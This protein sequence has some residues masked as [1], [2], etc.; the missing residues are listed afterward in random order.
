VAAALVA[1]EARLND[2]KLALLELER[3]LSTAQGGLRDRE[4]A[5]TLAEHQVVL[6]RE[7]AAGLTRRAEEAGAES[8]RMRERLEEVCTR[9]GE[10]A[11]KRAALATEREKAQ[12]AAEA[13]ELD[14]TAVEAELRRRR[15]VASERKQ[16]SLDLF[17]TEAEKRSACE[18]IRERQSSLA[19]RRDAA[20]ARRAEL[21]ARLGELERKLAL[22]VEE[23]GALDAG[24]DQAERELAEVGGRIESLDA[25]DREGA[26]ALSRLREEAAAAESRLN[27]LL[28][29]KR[30]FDG[31]SEGVKALLSA[32]ER[33]AGVVGVVADVLEVPA[34]YLD[35]LEAS[36]GEASAF[37]L[38]ED[39]AARARALERLRALES[40]RATLV[41]LESLSPGALPAVPE[42]R[43][44]VGRA[45]DLVRCG[46]RFRALVERL[47]GAVAVVE[48]RATA[49]LLSAGAEGG[50]R[51]VSLDGEVWER[52]R[53]RAGS[54]K[55][56]SGL[57]H[58][59]MQTRRS[60]SRPTSASGWGSRRSARGFSTSG[61]RRRPGSGN[62]ARRWRRWAASWSRRNARSAGRRRS[63]R[64]AAARWRRS[65]PSSIPWR[66]RSSRPRRSAT[67][68]SGSSTARAPSSPTSTARSSPW[69]PGARRP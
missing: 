16:L 8:S 40:G 12:A 43:G 60:R 62:G 44:V 14:L 66:A 27:T 3:E 9:E 56:L 1:I 47:L 13:A 61:R 24:R 10:A 50:L 34:R 39:R 17:S 32:G 19:E 59:E 21:D 4:E 63:R 35:A 49:A 23:R 33:P 30:N 11:E 64:I 42:G 46:G 20:A 36:L 55:N 31:V 65:K 28:E 38:V 26:A 58:R 53:V 7:R 45:S 5:R 69:K 68:S 2:E 52:G 41:D 37:V 67:R 18:R 54:A 25:R 48:D 51:F 29:L 6:L 15:D 57:L 22:G